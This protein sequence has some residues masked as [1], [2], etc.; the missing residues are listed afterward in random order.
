MRVTAPAAWAVSTAWPSGAA[1]TVAE[2]R[3]LGAKASGEAASTRTPRPGSRRQVRVRVPAG[4]LRFRRG[5]GRRGRQAR[6]GQRGAAPKP[7]AGGE[8]QADGGAGEEARVGH[9]ASPKGAALQAR[10]AGLGGHAV[11]LGVDGAGAGFRQGAAGGEEFE[12]GELAALV[13]DPGQPVGFVGGALALVGGGDPA[14]GGPGLGG[15]DAQAGFGVEADGGQPGLG[16]LELGPGGGGRPAVAVEQGQG[17]VAPTTKP[18]DLS[19][20]KRRTPR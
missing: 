11:D 4:R 3:H 19:S 16:A 9:G 2:A 18:V 5:G 14:G 1:A 10:E 15:A 6:S 8:D 20:P 13:A 7:A 17:A 12:D